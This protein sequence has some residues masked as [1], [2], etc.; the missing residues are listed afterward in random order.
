MPEA[1]ETPFQ[2]FAHGCYLPEPETTTPHRSTTGQT[3]TPHRSTTSQTTTPHRSTTGQT[4]TGKTTTP[5]QT[6]ISKE[7]YDNVGE[8]SAPLDDSTFY[9]IDFP[10]AVIVNEVS[11]RSTNPLPMN[12]LFTQF[13]LEIFTQSTDVPIRR[14]NFRFC[15]IIIIISSSK[16]HN[17]LLV[18]VKNV[19]QFVLSKAQEFRVIWIV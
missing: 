16:Y 7:C 17:E 14:V 8:A 1:P 12:S 15:S 3:T 9:Q 18:F 11:F 2:I 6:T 19:F 4:T 5:E 13:I 10:R